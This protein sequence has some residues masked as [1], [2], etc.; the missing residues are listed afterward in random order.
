VH[1]LTRVA[2]ESYG[3]ARIEICCAGDNVR[4]YAVAE[5]AGFALEGI[6]RNERRRQGALGDTRVYAKVAFPPKPPEP[7]QAP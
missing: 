4:S 2:F 5:R 6:L 7:A 1:G 3:A